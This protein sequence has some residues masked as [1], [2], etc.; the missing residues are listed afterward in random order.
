MEIKKAVV[1]G[2]LVL[3][4]SQTAKNYNISLNLQF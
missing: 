2:H 4:R 3:F 1:T